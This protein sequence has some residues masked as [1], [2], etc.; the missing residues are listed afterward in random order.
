[1]AAASATFKERRP[2]ASGILS[3]AAALARTSS[4]TPADFAPDHQEIVGTEG[5]VE[6]AELALRGE[7]KQPRL[8][9]CGAPPALEG[10]MGAVAGE[11]EMGE[12]IHAGTAQVTVGEEKAAGLDQLEGHLEAGREPHHGAG[13]LRDVGLIEDKAQSDLGG[14]A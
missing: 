13:V 12:I 8:G 7:Q 6:V 14:F 9:E 5:E 4:G 2:G 10:R 11:L 3:R 1:M